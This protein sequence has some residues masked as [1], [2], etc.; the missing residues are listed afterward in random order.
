MGKKVARIG[1]WALLILAFACAVTGLVA[2]PAEGHAW[3]ILA[4]AI[5]VGG[6]GSLAWS[7]RDELSFR[8]EE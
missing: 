2:P 1:G 4:C 5:F 8:L 3:A 6:L 7:Y